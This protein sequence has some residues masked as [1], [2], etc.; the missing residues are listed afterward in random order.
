VAL[1]AFSAAVFAASYLIGDTIFVDDKGD[2][3]PL[4]VRPI[5]LKE[6]RQTKL[7]TPFPRV[8]ERL[9]PPYARP[10]G[11]KKEPRGSGRCVYYP[12]AREPGGYV[13]MCFKRDRLVLLLA[14]YR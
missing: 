9:G 1:L 14:V 4:S 6:A 12:I 11:I 5:T 8:V 7:G 3:S 13:R 2:E 10:K